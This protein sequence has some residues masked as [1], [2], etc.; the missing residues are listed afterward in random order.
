MVIEVDG[1]LDK[2]VASVVSVLPRIEQV[3]VL[4]GMNS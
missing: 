1:H 4:R 3:T 2:K